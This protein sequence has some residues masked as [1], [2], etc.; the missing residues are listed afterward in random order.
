M[1]TLIEEKEGKRRYKS[2]DSLINVRNNEQTN[3]NEKSLV[4]ILI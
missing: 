1:S 4:S 2:K 3:K